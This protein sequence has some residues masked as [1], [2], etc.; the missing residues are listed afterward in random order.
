MLSSPTFYDEKLYK[1][2]PDG[3]YY[4]K[5]QLTEITQSTDPNKN[6]VTSE[7]SYINN[8]N[9]DIADEYERSRSGLKKS[10]SNNSAIGLTRLMSNLRTKDNRGHYSDKNLRKCLPLASE[11]SFQDDPSMFEDIQ[12]YCQL[13]RYCATPEENTPPQN[14]PMAVSRFTKRKIVTRTTSNKVTMSCCYAKEDVDGRVVEKGSNVITEF[15]MEKDRIVTSREVEA[16]DRKAIRYRKRIGDQIVTI[17]TERVK[18]KD[19]PGKYEVVTRTVISQC[20]ISDL[21]LVR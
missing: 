7:S 2:S 19:D 15:D 4:I 10:K 1:M 6:E 18:S 3:R 16:G 17:V 11:L 13:N 8:Q 12:S 14:S 20:S 5:D 9:F 21:Q